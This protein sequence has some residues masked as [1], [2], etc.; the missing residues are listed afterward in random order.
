M[1]NEDPALQ[2]ITNNSQTFFSEIA[3]RVREDSISYMDAVI[4]YCEK[5]QI[6][7]AAIAK[8]IKSAPTL[9]S[10]IQNEGEELNFLKKSAK[11][12]I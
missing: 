9:K 6:E 1:E 5:N 3:R 4:D 2:L 10:L 11:L 12:P 8:L 7:Y